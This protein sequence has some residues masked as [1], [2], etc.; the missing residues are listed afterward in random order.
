MAMGRNVDSV[1][2]SLPVS[3]PDSLQRLLGRGNMLL[4]DVWS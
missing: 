1:W 4:M 3:N 2:A